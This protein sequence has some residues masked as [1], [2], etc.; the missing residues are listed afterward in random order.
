MGIGWRLLDWAV[1]VAIGSYGPKLGF[2]VLWWGGAWVL[3]VTLVN[4]LHG[5]HV[6]RKNPTRV[7]SDAIADAVASIEDDPKYL[8]ETLEEVSRAESQGRLTSRHL[9]RYFSRTL[10][11]HHVPQVAEASIVGFALRCV[12][13][14]IG[15]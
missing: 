13:I 10:L 7:V 9:W 3:A 2:V 15:R 4:T 6:W 12:F 8:R 14:W 1:G 5:L 11:L